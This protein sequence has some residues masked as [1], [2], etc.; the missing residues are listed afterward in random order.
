MLC[1]IKKQTNMR[2]LFKIFGLLVFLSACTGKP[3][4]QNDFNESKQSLSICGEIYS[5]ESFKKVKTPIV[6]SDDWLKLNHSMNRITATSYK[7]RLFLHEY[8]CCSQECI[9]LTNGFLKAVDNGEFGGG[10][11]F[12]PF[13]ENK[14][15]QEV[16]KGNIPFMFE[17]K[18][19]IF[20]FAG[21]GHLFPEAKGLLLKIRLSDNKIE[22][23]KVL[24][25]SCRPQA[26]TISEDR[27]LVAGHNKFVVIKDLKEEVIIDNVFW[28]GLYPN[29]VALGHNDIVYIGIR[30]GYCILDL[31]KKDFDFYEYIK[32][33]E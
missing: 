24:E 21:G 8:N 26:F 1:G 5:K 14:D 19:E 30:G 10:L 7:E 28:Y 4:R 6:N 25:M 16:F 9:E 31:V 32:S 13:D 2:S 22:A 20:A 23:E 27:I 12:I 17:Y 11:Y 3:V 29:S 15:E 18:S 33:K